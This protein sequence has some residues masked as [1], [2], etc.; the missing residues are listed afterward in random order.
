LAGALAALLS[1]LRAGGGRGMAVVDKLSVNRRQLHNI[2][3][4]LSEGVILLDPTGRIVWA[5]E[6]ALT[7]YGVTTLDELGADEHEFFRNFDLRYRNNHELKAKDFPIARLLSGEGF[8]DVTVEVTRPGDEE[9]RKRVHCLRGMVLRDAQDD[10][11]SLV[12]VVNDETERYNAEDRFERTFNA[13]PAPAVICDVAELR[14]V[15]VNQGFMD[16]TG[17]TK[18]AVIGR[19]IYE[20]D[21]LE[22]AANRDDAIERLN[23]WQTIRQTEALLRLPMAGEKPVVVAGQPIELEGDRCMLFTFM[24]LEPRK[25]AETLLRQSEERFAKAFRLAPVPMMLTTLE[26]FKILDVND[27]FAAAMAMP[28]DEAIGKTAFDIELWEAADRRR[29]FE[30]GLRETGNVHNFEARLT[31]QAGVIDALISAEVVEISGQSCVLSVML[32]ITERKRSEA[33]VVAA[34]EA[35]MRDTSWFSQTVIEKLANLRAPQDQ[36]RAPVE[37]A[38]LTLRER[39]MLELICEGLSDKDI[40]Q[41]A[42]L[43]PHTVRNHVAA[44]YGKIGVHRRS[45]AIVWARARGITGARRRTKM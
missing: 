41:R 4:G 11:E 43:S 18:D 42:G 33:D 37:L 10:P 20:L 32:D 34:I 22:D 30:T 24:D 39:E 31:V 38:T 36:S 44:L 8:M 13:N 14:F 28:T 25:R 45:A 9:P 27:A 35:V 23:N 5:N 1:V 29:T 3:T 19:S 6:A 15:R 16:M 26:G 2:V 40:S 7:A 17:Y 12:L 21:V